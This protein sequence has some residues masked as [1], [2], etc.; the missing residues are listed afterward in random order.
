MKLQAKRQYLSWKY[1]IEPFRAYSFKE[2]AIIQNHSTKRLRQRSFR[3][4]WIGTARSS[5][6]AYEKSNQYDKILHK[7]AT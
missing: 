5:S 4:T 6:E 2:L 3:L 7:K 1:S